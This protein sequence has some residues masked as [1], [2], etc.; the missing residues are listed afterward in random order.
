MLVFLGMVAKSSRGNKA[1]VDLPAGQ[2]MSQ[3]ARYT[4]AGFDLTER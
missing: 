1:E 2:R 3:P 4:F